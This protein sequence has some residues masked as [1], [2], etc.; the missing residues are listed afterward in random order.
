MS[1]GAALCATALAATWA[2]GPWT[3]G[4]LGVAAGAASMYWATQPS[5]AA[6]PGVAMVDPPAP[7]SR[8]GP[9]TVV[10]A[11]ALALNAVAVLLERQ[12]AIRR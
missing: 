4:R 1:L 7:S 6:Y 10:A 8:K 9:Q 5:A 12:R 2:K 3:K 11:G